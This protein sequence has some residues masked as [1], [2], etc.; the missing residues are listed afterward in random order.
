M[1]IFTVSFFGHRKIDNPRFV[2]EKLEKIVRELILKKEYLEFLVGRDGE[3]DQLVAATIR[4]CKN[5]MFR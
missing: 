1:N 5:A 4:K 3:F 2:D